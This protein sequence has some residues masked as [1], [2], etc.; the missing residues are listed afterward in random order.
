VLVTYRSLF[1]G[2]YLLFPLALANAAINAYMGAH[3][4]GININTLPVVTVGADLESIMESTWS[5]V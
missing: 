5:A 2:L 1:A 3:D 4:I